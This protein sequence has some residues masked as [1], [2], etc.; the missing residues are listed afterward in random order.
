MTQSLR[1]R[2]FFEEAY[3]GLPPWDI[4]SPQ[5][6]FVLIEM[7]EGFGGSVL[8][9]GCGTGE[10]ALYLASLGHEVRGVDSSAAAVRK[11]KAKAARRNIRADFKEL[12]ALR[13]G[14]IGRTFDTVIDCGLF[15]VFSDEERAEYIRGLREVLRTGGTYYMLCF[16]DREPNWGGPRRISQDEIRAAFGEG[17]RINYIR[18][19]MLKGR[20][21]NGHALAWLCSITRLD[22]PSVH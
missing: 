13:L 14:A 20:I 17:W 12:D 2:Q 8:D 9:V 3:K 11:A 15:H 21:R 4:G 19:A 18:G 6:E 7:K 5:P 1:D 10:N 22:D 16:S